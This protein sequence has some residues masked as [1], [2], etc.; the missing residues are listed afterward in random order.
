MTERK[1]ATRY[2]NE[3]GR[4]LCCNA[5]PRRSARR[6][7]Y[8]CESCKLWIEGTCGQKPCEMC[9]GRPARADESEDERT[10]WA[11]ELRELMEDISNR[12]YCAG[13]MMGLER[14]LWAAAFEGK[15][16]GYGNGELTDGV[17][18]TL[19][20]RAERA[21]AWWHWPEQRIGDEEEGPYR[22]TLAE[23]RQLYGSKPA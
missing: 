8:Y 1:L 2:L 20:A 10:L 16:G 17:A 21:D 6:D 14:V 15:R 4:T 18:A 11:D 12:H 5:H 9:D 19:R 23:A 7:A 3:A 22:I 13:W